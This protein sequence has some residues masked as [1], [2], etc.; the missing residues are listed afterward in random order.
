MGRGLRRWLHR[1]GRLVGATVS[2]GAAPS[3]L[4]VPVM[5]G[6]ALLE[7]AGFRKPASYD[8]VDGTKQG[9]HVFAKLLAELTVEE[10]EGAFDVWLRRSEPW[11]PT[12]GQLL[13]AVPHRDDAAREWHRLSRGDGSAAALLVQR[14][15][16]LHPKDEV[17][18]CR[19][20]RAYTRN[21]LAME[22]EDR[23]YFAALKSESE[24]L[25]ML[26]MS[27]VLVIGAP[28][29]AAKLIGGIP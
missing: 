13:A 26:A 10:L 23:Q 1:R 27:G 29:R 14:T 28:S 15:G 21:W 16:G 22:P 3:P 12:P 5:Q 4:H 9:I 6:F 20:F 24:R 8:T 2:A 11:W 25:E 19:A 17:G 18:F 7:A